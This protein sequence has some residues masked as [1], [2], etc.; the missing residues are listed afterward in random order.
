MIQ[1]ALS[2][3]KLDTIKEG[4]LTVAAFDKFHPVSFY[5]DGKLEGIEVKIMEEYA[6]AAGLKVHFLR[7]GTWEGLWDKPRLREAD[8]AIGGISNSLGRTHKDTEW[9]M[10]YY[11]VRRSL[12]RLKTQKAIPKAK[13]R[14]T[15]AM[16]KSTG[17][18]DARWGEQVMKV[19]PGLGYVKDL[20]RLRKGALR[21]IMYGDNV[22]RAILREDPH[23]DLTM[24]TWDIVPTLVPPDG[25]T[26]SFPTRLGSGVAISLTSFLTYAA[27]SGRLAR[28][29]RHFHLKYPVVPVEK[30]AQSMPTGYRKKYRVLKEALRRFLLSPARKRLAGTEAPFRRL[31]ASLFS[32]EVYNEGRVA[33]L[34]EALARPDVIDHQLFLI[35]NDMLLSDV[36]SLVT[37]NDNTLFMFIVYKQA[38][39]KAPLVAYSDGTG[40]INTALAMQHVRA[41]G[42]TKEAFL[43][44]VVKINKLLVMQVLEAESGVK[45]VGSMVSFDF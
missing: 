26:F 25:E 39:E 37:G 24:D 9:S 34:K 14:P 4:V 8:V 5:Q 43:E 28:W 40:Y 45:N 19:A 2:H 36:C 11:Y 27:V 42:N 30:P 32:P 21:G 38:D 7:V 20:R 12:I 35:Y 3:R 18:I 15:S 33:R 22:S 6:Q 41:G 1:F 16:T 29:C 31:L 44:E 10:P 23:K 13:Y 17:Y